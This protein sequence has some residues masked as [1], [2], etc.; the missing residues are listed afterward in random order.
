[1][2]LR[3]AGRA[4]LYARRRH[5]VE[6]WRV[7]RARRR[8]VAVA[9]QTE[10]RDVAARQHLVIGRAVRAVAH[11]AAFDFGRRVLINERPLLVGVAFD[12]GRI[13]AHGQPGLLLLEAAVRVVAVA[14]LHRAFEH[15]M[16]GRLRELRLHLVVARQTELRVVADQHLFGRDAAAALAERA[17]RDQRRSRVAASDRW[18]DDALGVFARRV[19]RVAIH[20]ADIVAVVLAALVV[21][22]ILF[23]RVT[24]QAGVGDLFGRLGLEGANLGLVAAAFDVR[25]AW[26]VA[27]FAA[28]LL[29]LPAGVRKPGVFGL[30]KAVE[31]I[32]VAGLAGLATDK[33]CGSRVRGGC[34]GL[35]LVARFGLD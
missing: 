25:F 17:D 28:L 34:G 19:R 16:M 14:A 10:L 11:C 24:G 22:V 27:G 21:V 6:R 15:A 18:A 29:F 35:A 3:V 12:A 26:P 13:N 1:M 8:K 23:A 7:R 9:L 31:L 33:I 5:I 4:A 32:F 2:N 30:R 20:T